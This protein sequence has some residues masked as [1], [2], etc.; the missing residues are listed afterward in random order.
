L[1]VLYERR[2]VMATALAF[3]V[4]ETTERGLISSVGENGKVC[5]GCDPDKPGHVA[6]EKCT[7]CKGTGRERFSFLSVLTE[8]QETLHPDDDDDN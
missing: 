1:I 8:I 4:R 5:S 2:T 6:R 3:K 7:K